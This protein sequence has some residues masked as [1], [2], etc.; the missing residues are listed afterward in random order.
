MAKKFIVLLPAIFLVLYA[1]QA[2][3][4]QYN[5]S[6]YP[7]FSKDACNVCHLSHGAKALIK[8]PISLCKGCHPTSHDKDHKVGIK[9][10]LNRANLPLD[11][12]GRIVCAYTCHNMHPEKGT[13]FE[14]N[15]LRTD[16]DTLC[17]SCHE[18]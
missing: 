11:S 8:D 17:L 7:H 9:T 18:K 10:K 1:F 12:E 4:E 5:K 2:F 6:G 16:P 3:A 13:A 15:L 14:N